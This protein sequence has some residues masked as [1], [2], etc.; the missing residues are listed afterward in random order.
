M[1]LARHR[2][3]HGEQKVLARIVDKSTRTLRNW[4]DREGETGS[5]G[6]PPHSAEKRAAARVKTERAWKPLP[7]G[8]NG[9]RSVLQVLARQGVRVPTRLVRESVRALKR[10]RSA[11]EQARIVENR[12]HVE[13]LARDALW[14]LDQTFLMRDWQGELRALLV[15]ECLAPLTL[16]LSMG[17]PSCG[18]DVARL[19]RYVAS[20]CVRGTWPL[21][22]QFDNGSENDNALVAHLLREVRVIA[23]WN[24]PGTP[25]DNP[26]IE[27]T[28]G[29]L[30]RASGLGDLAAR[31]AERLQGP[32][33]ASDPGV[34]ATRT[35]A[36]SRLLA[37]WT[38]L[39]SL[40]PRV[41][42]MGLTPVELDRIA[43]RAEDLVSR[44]RFHAEVCEGWRRVALAP[45]NPP[46]R[47]KA[48]RE[49][50]W[51]TLQKY[52]LVKRTRGGCLVPTLKGE[53]I[54]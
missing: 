13:V 42:L 44:D 27:R 3:N 21:V 34:L 20:P 8:H 35:A 36:C 26:R 41:G 40:T 28:I 25:T 54:S 18:A 5:P 6:R 47:R 15:R 9:S 4:R 46:A 19:L 39:D 33:C 14:A 22:I 38:A 12:I 23:L 1:Y 31:G 17:G 7:R 37:A 10:E 50:V 29:G 24:E 32:V 53:G 49:V 51:S 48:E 16:G 30:K 52:G 43:H 2:L 45:L 11:R